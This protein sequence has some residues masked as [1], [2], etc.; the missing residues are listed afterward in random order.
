M[1]D[2]LRRYP[3]QRPPLP[4]AHRRVYERHYLANRNAQY[5]TT[6]ISQRMEAWMHRRVARDLGPGRDPTTL[7]IGA[8]TLNHLPYEPAITTYDV[9]EPFQLLLD[10]SRH[11][12]RIRH[13]YRSIAEVP[14]ANRYDR[15]VS[16][17]TFEHIEDLPDVVSRC[18]ALLAPGGCLRVGIPNEGTV[19]WRL[20]TAVTGLEYRINYGLDYQTLMRHEHVNTADEIEAVLRCFFGTVSVAVCGLSRRFAFYRFCECSGPFS[21]TA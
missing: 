7:E 1:N 2:I 4:E 13:T 19:L 15:I 18:A 17:A 8:G 14:S 21:G 9:V 6:S 20:G 10:D 12:A 5:R 16:I 3:K 11:R